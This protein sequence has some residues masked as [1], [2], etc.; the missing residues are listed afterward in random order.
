MTS[1]IELTKAKVVSKCEEVLSQI[2][3]KRAQIRETNI[4]RWVNRK[5]RWRRL[6]VDRSLTAA[7][8]P[9]H[10]AGTLYMLHGWD[11]EHAA[12]RL[13]M[14][15][16]LAKDTIHVSSEDIETIWGYVG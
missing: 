3:T 4:T 6:F 1:Y 12:S 10:V 14:T 2:R 7:D 16:R 11:A 8:A 15:A 13:L 5:N 9:E